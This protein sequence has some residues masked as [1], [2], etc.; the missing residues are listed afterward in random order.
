MSE[1]T[2]RIIRY[3]QDTGAFVFDWDDTLVDSKTGKLA[4]NSALA[5]KFGVERSDE[6][7]E[8]LYK[9]GLPLADMLEELCEH[10]ASY[11]TIWAAAE[12]DYN[13]PEY[14]KRPIDGAEASVRTLR[15]LGFRTALFSAASPEA[16]ELDVKNLDFDM[17]VFDSPTL[18]VPS[19]VPKSDPNAFVPVVNWLR[20]GGINPS[21]AVYVGDG[22]G[23]M[24][25]AEASGMKFIGV[26]QGLVSCDEFRSKGAHSVPSVHRLAQIALKLV[27]PRS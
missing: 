1:Y 15:S 5:R 6:D 17:S 4:Q 23:D 8:R 27:A 13:N 18:H 26:E 19:G 14:A 16:L 7:V 3:L 2:P 24:I 20:L 22:L 12:A 9:S 10:K 25:G 21:K 11:E